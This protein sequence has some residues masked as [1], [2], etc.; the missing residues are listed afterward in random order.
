MPNSGAKRLKLKSALLGL[1]DTEDHWRLIVSLSLNGVPSFISRGT[2]LQQAWALSASE[3]RNNT[4]LNLASKFTIH[5]K[6][7]FFYM[8]RSWDMGHMFYFPSEGRHAEDFFN[9]P[10]P[11]MLLWPNLDHDFHS[12][13]FSRS[14]TLTHHSRYDSS[15]WVIN[16]SQRPLPDNTQ[17]LQQINIHAPSRIR[18]H[19]QLQTYTL[20]CAIMGTAMCWHTHY[21]LL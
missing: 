20:H 15:G 7:R 4:Y 9:P 18:T 17:H 21:K 12:L 1:I 19:E 2:A 5:K 16:S 6:T 14:C 8:P 10:P 13:E 11:H 3:G